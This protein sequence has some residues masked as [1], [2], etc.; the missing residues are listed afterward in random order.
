MLQL[1]TFVT[2]LGLDGFSLTKHG[3]K[4]AKYITSIMENSASVPAW[5]SPVSLFLRT[6]QIFKNT[7]IVALYQTVFL[8]FISANNALC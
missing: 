5:Y 7:F 1:V 2:F 6:F 4:N 3:M 8:K